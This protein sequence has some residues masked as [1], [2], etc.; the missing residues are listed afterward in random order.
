MSYKEIRIT[1]SKKNCICS[2][3]NK[4]IYKNESIYI[5]P[6]TYVSHIKCH[7]AKAQ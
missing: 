7:N 5:I 2:N 3:C 6:G 4:Q 1:I